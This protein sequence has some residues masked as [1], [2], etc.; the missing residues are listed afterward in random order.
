M[1]YVLLIVP[2][3]LELSFLSK[4]APDM[5]V[6]E[7]KDGRGHF[8]FAGVTQYQDVRFEPMGADGAD[9]VDEPERLAR[10]EE[11]GSS[12]EVYAVHYKNVERLKAVLLRVAKSTALI[13]DD[14]YDLFVNGDEFVRRCEAASGRN[15]WWLGG[16][17]V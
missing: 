15:D 6:A 12:R 14:D 13:I 1:L 9:W 5:L 16:M 17:H 11:L 2:R 7:Q 10:I 4:A 8:V 3:R